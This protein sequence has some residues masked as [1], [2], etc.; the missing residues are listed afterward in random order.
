MRISEFNRFYFSE[1]IIFNKKHQMTTIL[2]RCGIIYC[3][4]TRRYCQ[5]AS[6]LWLISD[7]IIQQ[8]TKCIT[9]FKYTC[10]PPVMLCAT[11]CYI[12]TK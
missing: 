9:T 5:Q 8:I 1:T 10:S 7:T 11:Y 2:G 4:S 3:L 12:I 6:L